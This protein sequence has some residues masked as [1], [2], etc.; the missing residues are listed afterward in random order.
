MR[1]TDLHGI[2]GGESYTV[3]EVY[4]KTPYCEAER[5]LPSRYDELKYFL[6]CT[7]ANAYT[8]E[9]GRAASKSPH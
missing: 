7:V 9:E 3:P 1:M 8:I 6:Q 2:C 4:S 5:G